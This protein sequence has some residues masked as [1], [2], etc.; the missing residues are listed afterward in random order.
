MLTLESVGDLRSQIQAW[1]QA[2]Q[3]IGFVPTMG[4]L[5]AGHIE[6]VKEAQRQ[7]DKVVASI[8]VNPTQFGPYEDYENYPRTI[9]ADCKKLL[10]CK[11]DALFLPA[12]E[13]IYGA[14]IAQTTTV[15][16]PGLS[17]MLCGTSRPGHFSGVAT[18]VARLFNLVQPD[19][20]IFGQKDYQQL[21]VIRQ[22]T[23]DLAFPIEVLGYPTQ[24]EKDGLAMSS[25]NGYL[26]AEER[27]SAPLLFKSLNCL[28]EKLKNGENNYRNLCDGA[29]QD[30]KTVG[31]MP[32]YVEIRRLKDL[33]IPENADKSLIILAAA[34]LGKTRLIDNLPIELK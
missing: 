2:G 8:F 25:R 34:G 32:E 16:V 15:T 30:L 33:K 29:L 14:D 7:S 10:A 6:L 18:V 21:L 20:A 28:A 9:E 26:T 19:M 17:D 1:K 31:F 11:T 5:H 4:N 27:Q 12:V 23:S 3:R 13:A 24:R 22:M